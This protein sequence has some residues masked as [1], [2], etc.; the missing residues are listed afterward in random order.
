MIKKK[1][2]SSRY[3]PQLIYRLISCTIFILSQVI[4][5]ES[6]YEA[7]STWQNNAQT[8]VAS[9]KRSK[10]SLVEISVPLTSKRLEESTKNEKNQLDNIA[11]QTEE[12][13]QSLEE[14]NGKT[15]LGVFHF[16]PPLP[17]QKPRQRQQNLGDNNIYS[18]ILRSE[19]N[20]ANNNDQRKTKKIVGGSRKK[21][22]EEEEDEQ[23]QEQTKLS[24]SK[25]QQRKSKY[26]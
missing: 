25:E 19:N 3:P 10:E 26:S 13:A 21:D 6:I 23:E 15:K 14:P 20:K 5:A 2:D 1:Q 12:V 11:I 18:N 8:S 4:I 9:G 16:P 22:E 24:I 17:N 7:D